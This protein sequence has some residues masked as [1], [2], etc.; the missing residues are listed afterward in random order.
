MMDSQLVDHQPHSRSVLTEVI[1]GLSQSQKTLPA[2][3]LYDKRGSEIFEEICRVPSYYP[4]RTETQILKT[5][6]RE[7]AGFIGKDALIIEPGSGAAEKIRILLPEIPGK[8]RYVP[9]EI[10]REILLRTSADLLDE[11]DDLEIFPVCAD[12]TRDLV[13]PKSV[14]QQDGKKVVFFPGST[15]GNLD[16]EEAREFMN[17]CGRMV[18]AG[19][20]LLIGVDMKKDTEILRMAYNDPEG[21]TAAF[22]LN[23]LQRL[24][25]E[26]DASFDLSNFR[27]EAI[28]NEEKGRIEMHL[29]SCIPQMVR[30]NQTVF[31]FH[32]GETIHTENSYK[33]TIAEFTDLGKKAG[34]ALKKSWQDPRSLFSLYY[35]E[36]Q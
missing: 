5:H 22:N 2:K 31:R 7:M 12:F 32:K 17:K 15:I 36:C 14:S 18:G 34:L 30:V 3:L 19:G 28:Y 23:L 9:L 21:V 11:Y 29:E 20:G 10:S 26:V 6:A 27:H 13:L 25:R 4:T 24:N 8:K 35:F 16:P 1:M 33:Y